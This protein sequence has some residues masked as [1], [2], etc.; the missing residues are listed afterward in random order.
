MPVSF[1][2]HQPE[3]TASNFG[4]KQILIRN[5]PAHLFL[6]KT[7]SSSG[8]LFHQ[9]TPFSSPGWSRKQTLPPPGWSAKHES[10]NIQYQH[11]GDP[12]WHPP[13]DRVRVC[14]MLT[15]ASQPPRHGQLLAWAM[16]TGTALAGSCPGLSSHIH[17]FCPTA[18]HGWCNSASGN[19]PRCAVPF[20]LV[21]AKRCSRHLFFC[22]GQCHTAKIFWIHALLMKFNV[23]QLFWTLA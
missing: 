18:P 21:Q 22:S 14:L 5:T 10:L 4:N 1:G 9:E 7:F 19:F 12:H 17:R 6:E 20:Q 8:F 13:Q 23:S 11:W 3:R 2:G 16:G 15:P